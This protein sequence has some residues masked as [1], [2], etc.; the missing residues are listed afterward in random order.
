MKIIAY[1]RVST[2]EQELKNQKLE[3]LEYAQKNELKIHDFFEIKTSSRKSMEKRGINELFDQLNEN[4][5]LI[6]SELSRLG[7]SLGQTIQIVDTL[8]KKKVSFLAIKENIKING[9]QDIHTKVMVGMFGLFAE[10][11]RDLISQRTKAGLAA[12]RAKGR[13]GGR[14]KGQLSKSALDDKVGEIKKYLKL[15]VSV[16]SISKILKV[17]NSSLAYYIK[18]RKL[19]PKKK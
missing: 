4:D 13:I 6:V 15:G 7:R 16:T 17:P 2:D 8:I 11:E 12:A 9:S 14:K 10:I 5:Q 1:M 19:K 3:I 18:T